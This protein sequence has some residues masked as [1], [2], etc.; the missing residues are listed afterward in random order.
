[1]N[2]AFLVI[3]G[4]WKLTS[5]CLYRVEGQESSNLPEVAIGW[6]ADHLFVTATISHNSSNT[7]CTIKLNVASTVFIIN[8]KKQTSHFILCGKLSLKFLLV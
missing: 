2:V 4:E 7:L 5:I 1:M 8:T 3:V 6:T